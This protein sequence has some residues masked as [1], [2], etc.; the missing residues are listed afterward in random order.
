MVVDASVWIGG[1]LPQDVF[2][3]LSRAWLESRAK[4]R[5]LIVTPTLAPPEVAGAIARRVGAPA[6]GREA[7]SALRRTPGLRIVHPTGALMSEATSIAAEYRL[8]G[9]DAVYAA[10]ASALRLPLFTW[11]QELR[12]RT[13]GFIQALAPDPS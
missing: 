6:I 8:R 10:L 7:V 2:H 13:I 5:E 9:A 11:D 4:T 3:D 12:Q 1:L